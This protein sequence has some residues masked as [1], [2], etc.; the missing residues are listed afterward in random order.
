M[1][2]TVKRFKEIKVFNFKQDYE[3]FC[4]DRMNC[5]TRTFLSTTFTQEV[6]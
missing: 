1:W 6:Y 5:I 2:L 3:H 4:K